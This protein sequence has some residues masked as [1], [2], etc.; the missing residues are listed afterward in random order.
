MQLQLCTLILLAA[1]VFGTQHVALDR[2]L[3]RTPDSSSIVA[4]LPQLSADPDYNE[5]TTIVHVPAVWAPE[6]SMPLT[7]EL[8]IAVLW[9][10]CISSIPIYLR[11]RD[12]RAVTRTQIALASI[13]WIGIFGGLYLFTNV[14]LFQSRH[15]TTQRPLTVVECIYLMSQ[16]ITTVGYGDVTPARS[17]GQFFVGIYIVCSVL[18]ISILVGDV[19]EYIMESVKK[20]RAELEEA[21]AAKFAAACGANREVWTHQAQPPQASKLLWALAVF[22]FFALSWVLFF[23]FYPGEQ[24]TWMEAFYMSIITLSTVGFGAVTPDTEAGKV[25]A[26]FWMLFG[27]AALVNVI[28]AFTEFNAEFNN[29]ESFDPLINVEALQS[30]RQKTG[31]DSMDQMQ[32]LTF[33]LLHKGLVDQND[34]DSLQSSFK[35]LSKTEK[36][37]TKRRRTVD[38]NRLALAFY[39]A[40]QEM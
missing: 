18:V 5:E 38:L 9:V 39:Q 1:H 40:A 37:D 22:S 10:G 7:V 20:Y 13:L 31:A 32:F 15:F 36:P 8:L 4:S 11:V 29:Y 28:T 26:A 30:W 19:V 12:H 16:I 33:V 24:K 17:R 6:S 21:S 34:V 27:S 14:I 35:A 2:F 3:V 23:H 25:F